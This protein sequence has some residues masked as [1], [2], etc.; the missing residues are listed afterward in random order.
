M[1]I[2]LRNLVPFKIKG[3]KVGGLAILLSL[4]P[5]VI[6]GCGASPNAIL[7]S[8]IQDFNHTI[9]MP[10]IR[11]ALANDPNLIEPDKTNLLKAI[12]EH[13]QT[14]NQIILND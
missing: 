8:Q 5:W 12:D 14:I 2:D 11:P 9:L 7:T 10:I 4:I 3:G 1:K 6:L 13:V